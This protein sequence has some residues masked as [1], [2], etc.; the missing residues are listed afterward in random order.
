MW[1]KKWSNVELEQ[2]NYCRLYL[3]VELVSDLMTADGVAV[4]KHLWQG[5]TDNCHEFF[6]QKIYDQPRPGNTAWSIWRRLLQR[7]YQCDDNGKFRVPK[8]PIMYTTDW[9]WFLD[10]ISDR[11]YH[12]QSD[13]W[14]ERPRLVTGRRTRQQ[15]YGQARTVVSPPTNL[16]PLSTYCA[17]ESIK[18]DG[19]GQV[20]DRQET[21]EKHMVSEYTE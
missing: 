14:D 7:T 12:R 8:E 5:I 15:I 6:G 18:I 4:R 10:P 20:V 17:G 16:T 11:I 21:Q 2:F 13:G 9:R 19:R 1:V 3:R